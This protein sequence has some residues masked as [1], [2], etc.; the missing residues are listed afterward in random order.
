MCFEHL[1]VG[2]KNVDHRTGTAIRPTR[3]RDN[4]EI[5]I[6]PHTVYTP[7]GTKIVEHLTST[8]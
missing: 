2:R 7:M 1:S 4:I 6:Q 5:L 3:T 8:Q